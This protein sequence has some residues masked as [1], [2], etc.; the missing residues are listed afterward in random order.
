MLFIFFF[1]GPGGINQSFAQEGTRKPAKEKVR[2]KR[3]KSSSSKRSSANR[4]RGNPFAGKRKRTEATAAKEASRNFSRHVSA[5]RSGERAH[6]GSISGGKLRTKN[7]SS[8]RTKVQKRSNPYIGRKSNSEAD[9]ARAAAKNR[10]NTPRTSS[11]G[12][13]RAGSVMGG[14]KIQ[15]RTSSPKSTP[16]RTSVNPYMGSK[17]RTEADRARA[18]AKNTRKRPPTA[19]RGGERAAARRSVAGR[20]SI[21]PGKIGM[22]GDPPKR[23]KNPYRGRKVKEWE[24]AHKGD[25]TGRKVRTKTTT[26][27][28]EPRA[29]SFNPYA[30]RK[31]QGERGYSG[32]IKP[33]SSSVSRASESR[34]GARSSASARTVT[35]KMNKPGKRPVSPY[36]GRKKGGEKG[37]SGKFQ[38]RSQSASQSSES[39]PGKRTSAAGRSISAQFRKPGERA[40]S[41]YY[42]RKKGGEQGYSGRIKPRMQSASQSSES[43]PGKRAISPYYGRK[44]G[45]EQGYSGRLEPRNNSISKSA[46]F[47]GKRPRYSGGQYLSISAKGKTSGEK[48]PQKGRSKD[49][50]R[51]SAYQGNLKA[52]K[53][54]KG[55]GGS[56]SGKSWN[57]EGQ[58]TTAKV[59]SADAERSSSFSGNLK[60]RKEKEGGGGSISGISWN[61]EGQSTTAKVRSKDAERS[62]SYA[63]NLKRGKE[64]EGGGGSISGRSWNN[65]GQPLSRKPVSPGVFLSTRIKGGEKQKN[66]IP[67]KNME[68]QKY[69]GHIKTLYMHPAVNTQFVNYSGSVKVVKKKG[70]GYHP[71]FYFHRGDTNSQEEKEKKVSF[72]LLWNKF[73]RSNQSDEQKKKP[74][75]LEFDKREIGLWY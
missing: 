59:R 41:P 13:E 62:S 31:S 61:N 8:A 25:I 16:K 68:H 34:P 45:G 22:G 52:V 18:A 37:Y 7:T 42:G 53:P 19:T 21:Q 40:I 1:T 48:L 66:V 65:E 47:G 63:G 20:S 29:P 56:I 32:R 26:G 28:P 27:R 15:P 24:K 33:Q 39:R 75:K 6:K 2:Q 17:P 60:A 55:A 44:K 71:S 46:E 49:A 67:E 50:E 10:V 4:A 74:A 38:T 54:L 64:E 14:G 3:V 12:G 70:K 69:K 36:Y 58:S 51:Q 72:K 11:R 23:R 43:K 35:G 9:R 73:F 5:T 30:G 57:N